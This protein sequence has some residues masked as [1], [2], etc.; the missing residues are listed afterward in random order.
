MRFIGDHAEGHPRFCVKGEEG[1]PRFCVK[2]E[3]EHANVEEKATES[4]HYLF[5]KT[6]GDVHRGMRSFESCMA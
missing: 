5:G 4:V 2:G 6:L 1:H 3:E